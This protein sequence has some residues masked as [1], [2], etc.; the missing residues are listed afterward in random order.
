MLLGIPECEKFRELRVIDEKN[1]W[2][3]IYN[4]I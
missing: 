4:S 2:G 3:N 1:A